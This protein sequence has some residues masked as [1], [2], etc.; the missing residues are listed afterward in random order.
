MTLASLQDADA[1]S[2]TLGVNAMR[3]RIVM[4]TSL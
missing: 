4:R 2:P 1:L 3:R